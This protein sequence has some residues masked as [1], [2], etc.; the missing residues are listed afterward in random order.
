M[1]KIDNDTNIK[2]KLINTLNEVKKKKENSNYENNKDSVSSLNEKKYEYIYTVNE[3]LN[4][5]QQYVEIKKED[6]NIINSSNNKNIDGLKKELLGYLKRIKK[7]NEELIPQIDIDKKKLKSKYDNDIKSIE[8]KFNEKIDGIKI[9]LVKD[10]NHNFKRC[11]NNY[12]ITSI[13]SHN[14]WLPEFVTIG[15]YIVKSNNNLKEINSENIL[16][17]PCDID[18]KNEGNLVIKINSDELY[19]NDSL[20]ENVITGLTLKY[21]ESF[22]S[23]NLQVGIYSSS[24]TSFGKLSAIFAASL[25]G[26]IS[27]TDETCKTREQ[28]SR[29]LLSIS[30][31]GE[32]VNS[33]LLE[34][35]CNSIYDLYEK[36]IKTEQFQLVI[37]HDA[38]REMSLD[39][40]NQLHGCIS[41]LSRSGIRFIII[42]DFSDD[43]YKNKPSSFM[44]KM[45]QI[46]DICQVFNID[47]GIC[48][49]E[50][51]NV[52]ELIS[53]ENMSNNSIFTFINKYLSYALENKAPYLSYEK[54]GFGNNTSNMRDF[55]SISIPV[56]LVD[57]DIWEIKFDCVGKAPIAN[58]IVGV[59]GTGKSTLIDSLIMNGAMKYSPDELNF[60]LLDFKDGISS[61][62][63]SMEKCQIPHIKVLS[64]NNKPE[65]ADIILSNIL[66]ESER[67]NK[68]FEL[69]GKEINNSIRDISQYNKVV[70]SGNY[71]RNIMPRL[72]IV[73]DECQYLFDNEVLSKKC[74]D[75][76]RKCRSQGIH[77]I[78]ATQTITH[79]M[80]NTIKF[81]DGR[82][83][84]EINEDDAKQLINNKYASIIHKEVP[85]GSY[86]AFASNDGGNVCNK[87]IIS[88]D[89]G[90]TAKYSTSIRSK[91]NKYPIDMVTVGDKSA[92]Y[93]SIND[94][95]NL[96]S[97]QNDYLPIGENYNDHSTIYISYLEKHPLFL[98]GSYQKAADSILKLVAFT[99][100][101]KNIESYIVDASR[102]Q[103]LTDFISSNKNENIKITNEKGYLEML[104]EIYDIYKK[105]ENDLRG[106]NKPIFFIVNSL[107][108]IVDFLNNEK[109]Q[110]VVDEKNNI[111]E[112][113]SMSELIKAVA[114]N[115]IHQSNSSIN[116]KDT[117]LFLLN[118]AYKV[119][120]FICVSVDS[121]SLT[122]DLGE[123]VFGFSQR[124][125]IKTSDYKI[126]YPNCASDI[127]NVMD[128]SFKE[129]MLNGLSENMAFLSLEQRDFYKFRYFQ[130][131]EEED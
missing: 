97:E 128:D 10:Y 82:Y 118:N 41:E 59:P 103:E 117:L 115:R 107:Q 23:G 8:K 69:L 18:I 56:A 83:C 32:I 71:N 15:N 86:R 13:P 65:E 98:G 66:V 96:L 85:K 3:G 127:R 54:I 129:K 57:S 123:Q 9:P 25:K 34:N 125:I 6:K 130:L 11:V 53:A 93:I 58:L 42:D 27:V 116:G 36:D 119:N 78:L 131:I 87:I 113:K 77:L 20:I 31:K 45:N 75:I 109:I 47:N 76:V 90:N 52:I 28:F 50:K 48:K 108:S 104:K 95:N 101:K 14:D 30:N 91:W 99:A 19:D 106:D 49:D 4:D 80:W 12:N 5:K 81:V 94:Y 112:S 70:S 2:N 67:R 120:I 24:I 44:N 46:L 38:F 17:V 63:Y 79:K 43:I 29:L 40:I 26:N 124:N 105:R 7:I 37:I 51:G 100:Y 121:V 126:L 33:K 72:V 16:K 21:I 89:G 88:Y 73:I 1:S 22:P 39:N 110:Q 61:S 74:E 122:N 68:Q 111:N 62:V 60:Q 55:D 92:K 84:F 35:N 102:K 114:N 64:Q